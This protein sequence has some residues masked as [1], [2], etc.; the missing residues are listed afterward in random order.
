MR[1]DRE[2]IDSG[3]IYNFGRTECNGV[4]MMFGSIYDRKETIC[5]TMGRD[6]NG[7]EHVAISIGSGRKIPSWEIMCKAKSVF[8]RDD[9]DVVQLHPMESAYF[10]GFPGQ[11]EVLHLWRPVDGDWSLLNK[12]YGADGMDK[13]DETDGG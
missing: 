12:Y 6:E 9:E 4:K 5:F 7:W 1:T 2:I 11:M 13:A 10:H 8:W 3:K